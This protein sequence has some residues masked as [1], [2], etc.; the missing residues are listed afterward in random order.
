[1]SLFVPAYLQTSISVLEQKLKVLD[2]LQQTCCLC[3][4][5]CGVDRR[6]AQ[7]RCGSTDE[8]YV[9]SWG[10]HFGEEPFFSDD[11]GAGTVFFAGCNAACVYCQN[12]QISQFHHGKLTPIEALA[13]IF[14]QLQSQGC[15]NLDLVTPTH[16][17]PQIVRA[18]L[19]A[20][21]EGFS[22]PLLYNT[23][24]YDS[25]AL[26]RCLDGI[27]DL[28]LPDIK[29]ASPDAALAYSGLAD[30][31][32]TA[33]LAVAEMIAQVGPL[34]VDPDGLARR[35]VAVRHLVLP[36]D[37]SGSMEV[38]DWISR[39]SLDIQ[40]C[41]MSQY[42]PLFRAAETPSLARKVTALEYR[43]VLDHALA[44]GF[45][46]ILAQETESADAFIPDFEAAEPFAENR[47]YP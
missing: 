43:T 22:L 26:I 11:R 25:V 40:L 47:Q 31:P 33:F 41:L 3:A 4:H 30:Y 21:P 14:L 15:H 1:M 44:L 37:I 5:H 20:I 12:Y 32:R 27:V 36:H 18:L 42:S 39:Q 35:G 8:V 19:L 2:S 7:G 28:Y 38:L 45:E 16:Y 24:A 17:M 23:N 9:A 10:P 46:N 34:E 29:Y 13:D 6:L